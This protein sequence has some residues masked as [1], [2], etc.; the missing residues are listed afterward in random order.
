MEP[1]CGVCGYEDIVVIPVADKDDFCLP[2]EEDYD[3][4]HCGFQSWGEEE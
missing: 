1:G 3:C 4:P 2:G